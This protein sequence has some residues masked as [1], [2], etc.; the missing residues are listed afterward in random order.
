M[1]LQKAVFEM[2]A[3]LEKNEGNIYLKMD[4]VTHYDFFEKLYE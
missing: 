3:F 4:P 1:T 2:K